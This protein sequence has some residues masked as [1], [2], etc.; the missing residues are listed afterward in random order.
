[1]IRK[2]ALLLDPSTQ[3]SVKIVAPDQKDTAGI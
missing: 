1:M 3:A 2:H